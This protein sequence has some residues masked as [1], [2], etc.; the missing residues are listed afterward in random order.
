MKNAFPGQIAEGAA[1]NSEIEGFAYLSKISFVSV[2]FHGIAAMSPEQA[3]AK[4][5]DY[6]CTD[7][8]SF[9]AVLYEMASGQMPFQGESTAT[10]FDNILNRAH[11]APL[12]LNPSLFA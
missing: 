6:S 8:F 3:R 9:G 1:F 4:E 2:P 7:L 11:V 5:L 12:R 10:I